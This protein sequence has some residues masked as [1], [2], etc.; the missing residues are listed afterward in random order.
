M[1]AAIAGSWIFT[2]SG[3]SDISV[4]VGSGAGD[5]PFAPGDTCAV[6]SAFFSNNPAFAIETPTDSGGNSYTEREEVPRTGTFRANVAIADTV[7]V[8][9]P[10]QV[11]VAQSAGTISGASVVVARITGL[12]SPPFDDSDQNALAA[13][14]DPAVPAAVASI[15]GIALAVLAHDGSDTTLAPPATWTTV[16]R[17]DDNSTQAISVA[18]SL[19]TPGALSANWVTGA[20]RNYAGASSIYKQ[21]SAGPDTGL[22]WIRA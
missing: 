16:K 14:D 12:D 7:V 5:A 4:S 2:G 10:T 21:L 13:T 3:A 11:T 20:A 17:L 15:D 18:F 6:F 19:V 22:A 8:T 1:P 9:P